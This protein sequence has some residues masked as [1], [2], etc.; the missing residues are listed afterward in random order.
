MYL[1]KLTYIDDSYWILQKTYNDLDEAS[2]VAK[3][4]LQKDDVAS[5]EIFSTQ[6]LAI[7]S[8]P[9]YVVTYG[10]GHA[11]EYETWDDLTTGSL[12]RTW[13]IITIARRQPTL[14]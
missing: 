14:H 9:K 8:K 2:D 3:E 1:I 12:A 6:R 7:V 13:N 11:V 4:Q 10:N 5:Y